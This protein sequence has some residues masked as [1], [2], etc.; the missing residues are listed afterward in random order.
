MS[1]GQVAAAHPCTAHPIT[2]SAQL[3]PLTQRTL[4]RAQFPQAAEHN[5]SIV[6]ADPGEGQENV[7]SISPEGEG[8]L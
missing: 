7:F 4:I 6:G 3:Y 8:L 2:S 1:H 5:G